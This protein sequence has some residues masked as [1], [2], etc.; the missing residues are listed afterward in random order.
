MVYITGDTHGGFDID[1]LFFRD[2]M[3]DDIVIICGDFGFVWEMDYPAVVREQQLLNYILDS[4]SCT[5]LFVDGNHENFERL[6]KLP[7]I[8]KFGAE[9]GVV[10]D[11]CYHLLRGNVYTIEGKTYLAIGGAESHDKKFR[12]EG[13]S[14]WKEESITLADVAKAEKAGKVDFV[15]SH[16]VP[17]KVKERMCLDGML[18]LGYIMPSI[19]EYMLGYLDENLEYDYW[20]SGHY[21]IDEIVGKHVILYNDFVEIGEDGNVTK[22]GRPCDWGF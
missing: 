17:E 18:P 14:W 15:I 5:V 12:K 6:N 10:R 20:F 3:P 16:C 9:V 21:H 8:E 2:F 11:G 1:K 7:R 19:S 4:I 13:I 22:N